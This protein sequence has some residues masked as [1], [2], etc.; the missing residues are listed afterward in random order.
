MTTTGQETAND[1]RRHPYREEEPATKVSVFGLGYVGSV[2]ASCLA[3]N[4]HDVIGIDL[5]RAKVELLEAGR[6]PIIEP[7]LDSI[8]QS[9][10]DSGRLRFTED[11]D[12]AVS[13]TE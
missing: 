2:S 4:G 10:V 1:V 11:P 8:I 7:G 3:A 13:Q 5:D 9:A 12:E 6:S